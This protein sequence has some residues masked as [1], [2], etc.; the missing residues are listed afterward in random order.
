MERILSKE[1]SKHEGKKVM[2]RGWL[3]N[4]RSLGKIN[5]VIVRDRKG[6][7]QLVVTEKSEYQKVKD[8]QP[9]SVLKVTGTVQVSEQ[10]ESGAEIIDPVIEVEVPIKEVPPIEY[11]KPEI[12]ADI[13]TIL[14]Y[15]TITLR[16]RKIKAVFKIQAEIAH[17]YREYMRNEVDATEYFGP[18]IIGASSEGGSEI[19]T[20]DYFDHKATLA[21]SSQL[22]KQVMVGVAERAFAIMP[23]FR[24][25]NSNTVRHLTEGKQCEFEMGFFETWHDVMDVLEGTMKHIVKHVNE[26]CKDE[27]KTLGIE[28]IRAPQNIA[29][30][31]VKFADAQEI[32]F[33]RT[34]IDERHENDLSPAAEKGLCK[35]AK[36][37]FGTDCIFITDWLTSKRPFY[38]Y[39]NDD[40]PELTN[41]FDL[42][43]NG[44]EVTSG[45]QR[46]HTYES[47]VE[48]LKRKGMD[49][50]NF[51]D[52][53]SI[54]KYGMP[55][56]GGFGLGFERLTMTLLG[57][58]NVRE[59]SLFPSD[60]K[61][62]AG[63]R[64]KADVVFGAE[65]LRN[66][67][68]RILKKNDVEFQHSKHEATP[69]SE[70]SAR[71]RGTKLTEGVK[72]IILRGKSSKENYQFNVPSN[73]KLDLKKVKEIVGEAC[74]F[75][76]PE[77]IKKRYGIVVGGVPPF[78]NLLGIKTFFDKRILEEKKAAF[79]C[80]MQE[81]SIV[82]SAEDL[83]KI[84]DPKVED[85]A[86]E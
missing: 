17:A 5:F 27:L 56:H 37:E 46:C 1:L 34:G 2:I 72:A 68:V 64:I 32:Y 48:G 40:N 7:I 11:T 50:A 59:V 12:K 43:C 85:F 66:E 15:R 74:E 55:A 13:E 73:M 47:L 86:K 44:T 38:S 83:V 82:M 3:N 29:F 35:Y 16:N 49:P 24:A 25:E 71:V 63:N 8:L 78:G 60:P 26:S 28:I 76:D 75:E 18:N 6:F 45:G 4:I 61:R 22:Y 31:R 81:E 51:D 10:A 57:L 52:Y 69:T 36:E 62:I 14:D 9:G 84:V 42:L 23:F 54:F 19:F 67:I 53:L 70:D 21:Q 65:N 33:K 41:T 58:K 30:P 80:G 77:V 20:V 39:V 79:N